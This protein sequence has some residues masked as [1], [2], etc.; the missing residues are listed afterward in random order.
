MHFVKMLSLSRFFVS[1][2]F[3]FFVSWSVQA[4]GPLESTLEVFLV[5]QVATEQGV[6]ERLVPTDQAEPGSTLEY[7][8]TY[9]NTGSQ[10]LTDFVLKNPISINTHYIGGSELSPSG[11]EFNVSIDHGASYESVPVVRIVKDENGDEKELVVSPDQYTSL[12][13]VVGERLPA[14]DMMTIRYR[15]VIK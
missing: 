11:A 14:G 6:E 12:R 3:L 15:V 8:A 1:F 2:A 7:V 9:K 13:W 4:Q 10:S 5:E